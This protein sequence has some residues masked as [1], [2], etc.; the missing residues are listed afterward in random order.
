[1]KP[2]E[3]VMKL[4]AKKFQA[5][6]NLVRLSGTLFWRGPFLKLECLAYLFLHD[7]HCYNILLL[8]GKSLYDSK[9]HNACS[10]N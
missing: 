8:V 9:K 2:G 5:K 10:I 1:M 4:W 7:A 6:T 3:I